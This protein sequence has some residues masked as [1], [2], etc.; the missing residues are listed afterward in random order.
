MANMS[1]EKIAMP[2]QDPKVRSKNFDEVTLGYTPE[3]AMEEAA[4][5]INCKNKPCVNGCPVKV[6]IPEFI[7]KVASGEFEEA[8]HILKSTNALPAVCGRVCPQ[9]VQC[10]SK[11]VRGIKGEPVAIGRLER[12]V[13]DYYMQNINGKLK[14]LKLMV[15][16]WLLLVRTCGAYLC[17]RLSSK[18]YEVTVLKL[19]IL[20]AEF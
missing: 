8:Y 17:W 6:R 13:V 4:R 5:C 9:E 2:E 7:S 14:N 11:C 12:F 19:F 15:I 3:M 16:K 10:E 1:K 20:L 18:G